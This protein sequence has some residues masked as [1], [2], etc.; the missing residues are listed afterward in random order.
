MSVYGSYLSYLALHEG[1]D[2][3]ESEQ[4]LEDNLGGQEVQS[5]QQLM[6]QQSINKDVSNSVRIVIPIQ[7][8]LAWVFIPQSV[9]ERS[10]DEQPHGH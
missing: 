5:D 8:E 10:P 1:L 2:F 6:V 7:I 9:R 3:C 4:Q